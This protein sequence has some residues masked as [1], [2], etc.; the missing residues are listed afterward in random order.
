[1]ESVI[2]KESIKN[3][4]NDMH[5]EICDNLIK[6]YRDEFENM[7]LEKKTRNDHLV[8]AICE[9]DFVRHSRHKHDRTQKHQKKVREIYEYIKK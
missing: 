9:G 7:N 2:A 1:M 4:Y 5:K 3:L 6:K 8:C